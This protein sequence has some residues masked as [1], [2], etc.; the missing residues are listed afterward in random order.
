MPC[1]FGGSGPPDPLAE[2]SDNAINKR[3]VV[4]ERDQHGSSKKEPHPSL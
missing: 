4:N 1:D 3:K 2:K